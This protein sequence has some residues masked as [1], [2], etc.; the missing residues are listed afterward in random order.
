MSESVESILDRVQ[1]NT[2]AVR[3]T[4]IGKGWFTALEAMELGASLHKGKRKDGKTP[5]FF[6]QIEIAGFLLTIADMLLYPEDTIAVSF[7]HDA[8]EDY[9]IGFEE[10][11][12]KFNG[13]IARATKL[14]TKTHRGKKVLPEVYFSEMVDDAISSVVKGVDRIH[15]Q[16][17]MLGVFPRAKQDL[18]VDETTNLILPML[19]NARKKHFRQYNAYM[20]IMFVLKGQL[21][22]IAAMH[23]ALDKEE[24]HAALDKEEEHGA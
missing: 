21:S 6:H 3:H 17:S 8:P 11:E 23:A 5:E 15:N 22:M 12:S 24:E 14:I 20:N 2:I 13:R 18:Y 4:L 7:L 9:D 16:G 19:K 10:L 1:R